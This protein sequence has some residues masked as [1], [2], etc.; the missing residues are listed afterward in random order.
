MFVSNYSKD[1]IGVSTKRHTR[2]LALSILMKL[3][4]QPLL[5]DIG[6]ITHPPS[7][8]FSVIILDDVG[9]P[10]LILH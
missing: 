5:I 8:I 2:T 9:L 3:D 7:R 10:F 1:G 4:S 6:G